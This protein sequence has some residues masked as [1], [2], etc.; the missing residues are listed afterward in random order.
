MLAALCLAMVF[1]IS[2]SS[3]VALC[4]TSLAM[5]T[6]NVVSSR[7]LEVAEAGIEQALYACNNSDWTGWN[8]STAG[9]TT[10]ATA[11]MT[12]T[13]SGLL[14]ASGGPTPLNL[15]NGA[16][17]LANISIAYTTAN[18]SLIQSITSQGV[19]TL[20]TGSLMSGATPTISRTLSYT[21]STTPPTSAAPVFVNA[22]AATSGRVRFLAAGTL[23]SYISALT[24]TSYQNYT[25]AIA[26][27]SATVV[28]SDPVSAN[29][30]V[31]LNDAVVQ[32]YVE[33]YDFSS[34]SSTNWLSYTAGGKVIGP[35]TPSST[36]IDSSRLLS[37]P[38]P[39]QPVFPV[40]T[41]FAP[42]NLPVGSS[43]GGNV[44]DT[45]STLGNP[46]S[47][48]PVV[49]SANGIALTS[50]MV[51]IDGPVVL[52][53][54]GPGGP[55]DAVNISNSGGIQLNGMNASLTIIVSGG[56]TKILGNGITNSSFYPLPKRVA[57]IGAS[58]SGSTV[59]LS[60]SS[61]IPFYGVVYFPYQPVAISTNM[62]IFGSVVGS[63][64]TISGSPAIHYDRALRSPDLAAS[65]SAFAYFAAPLSFSS[66]VAS[67]P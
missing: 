2:L 49:Y 52:V 38:V 7:S 66:L 23:D 10:T 13:A 48:I 27:F 54:V 35:N 45:P 22:V 29:S 21:S 15:G 5:S 60:Q 25:A 31:R 44:L 34:P 28:S 26:G 11:T 17:A 16:N 32:G 36:Y 33:G 1:A 40:N 67:V 24:P 46:L 20:P 55:G 19:V 4:Y 61:A 37:T 53:V 18:P 8:I 39:Y 64:V 62:Q 58:P 42:Q 59:T 12:V 43:S 63:T 30:T 57:L 47:P 3:Y 14:P 41:P 51:Y 50:G 9:T 65:D 56:N 6:R